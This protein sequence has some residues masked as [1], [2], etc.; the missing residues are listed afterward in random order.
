MR[1]TNKDIANDVEFVIRELKNTEVEI[2]SFW[3]CAAPGVLFF[4]ALILWST[5]I[6]WISPTGFSKDSPLLYMSIF[7]GF[8]IFLTT[9][10][11]RGKY[12]SLPPTVQ[13][14]S[15]ILK[16]LKNK[17]CFYCLLWIAVNIVHGL[18]FGWYQ[19]DLFSVCSVQLS[20]LIIIWF[21]AIAD[22][23]RYDLSLLSAAIEAWR[24]GGDMGAIQKPTPPPT[25][26][27]STH[28]EQ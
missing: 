4:V 8:L 20:S 1:I 18:Y 28:T 27:G 14:N 10:Q 24:S 9:T 16:L 6:W 5:F 25:T 2:P 22:L 19:G 13:R 12:L 17:A 21:I 23:G 26:Q 7:L 15:I 3:Q 11:L